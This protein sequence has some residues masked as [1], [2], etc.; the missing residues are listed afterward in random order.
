M[1]SR[2]DDDYG[3]FVWY[4]QRSRIRDQSIGEMFLGFG[5]ALIHPDIDWTVFEN[6]GKTNGLLSGEIFRILLDF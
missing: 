4:V 1:N 3:A 6:A 5:N 2:N